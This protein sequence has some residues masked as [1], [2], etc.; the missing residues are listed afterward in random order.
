MKMNKKELIFIIDSPFPYY[1]GGRETWLNHILKRLI[2]KNYSILLINKRKTTINKKPFF[3]PDKKIKI[4]SIPTIPRFLK[5]SW[6]FATLF[7]VINSY[8]FSIIA[9]VKLKNKY[10]RSKIKPLIITLNPGFCSYP[11]LLLRKFNFKYVC[12]VRGKYTYEIVQKCFWF[13][14]KWFKF[15]RKLEIKTLKNS[16]KILTNGYDTK[17]N[18]RV[19]LNSKTFQKIEVLPNG[20]N[21]TKFAD[22]KVTKPLNIN[23]SIIMTVAT[24][25][26]IKGIPQIIKSIPYV[27]KK[28]K[29]VKFVFVGKGK[30]TPYITL[31]EKLNVLNYV[32]FLGERKDIPNLLKQAKFSLC[33]SGGSG[34]SH[35]LLESLASG[36][37]VIAWD[38][39]VYKQ[40]INNRRNGLLVKEWDSKAL[41]EGIKLVLKNKNLRNEFKKNGP[42]SVKKYDWQNIIERLLKEINY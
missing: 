19:Y 20:V 36:T 21:Y 8:L 23:E 14:K 32:S 16:V 39:N 15:F 30:Q 25:R 37:S 9:F 2:R 7:N 38:S 27:V 41:A 34:I 22:A 11:A 4:I 13:K 6:P 12:C 28:N 17:E 24:L 10:K 42:K 31:A 1:S 40:I 18:L 3:N 5:V 29:N 26:D 33:L 35:S